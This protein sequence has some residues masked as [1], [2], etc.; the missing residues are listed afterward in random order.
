MASAEM[1]KEKL[2]MQS[3]DTP[4]DYVKEPLIPDHHKGY[5]SGKCGLREIKLGACQDP[6]NP[7]MRP[8]VFNP[9]SSLVGLVSLIIF[10]MYCISEGSAAK[11]ELGAWQS[12]VT[13]TFTWLY[14]GS[15]DAWVVFL[16]AVYF[17]FGNIRLGQDTDKPEFT[18]LS[19]FAMIFSCGVAVGLFVYGTAEPL[20]HYG[21][22]YKHSLNGNGYESDVEAA[23]MA[24]LT[25]VFH[26]GFHGWV[27]YSLVAIQLGI[28]SFRYNLP[29][30]IR[31]CFYPLLGRHTWGWIGDFIDGFSIVTIIAG[32]CTSLGLGAIQIRR[33]LAGMRVYDMVAC[34]ADCKD[35]KLMGII[36]GITALATISVVSGLHVGIKLLS[37]TALYLSFFILAVTLFYGDTWFFLNV[38]T[39]Q[40]GLYLHYAFTI[41]GFRTD[42]FAQLTDGQGNAP[43]GAGPS[44]GFMN[45]WTIFYWG[46]WIAWSPFVGSFVARISRGRTIRE[47]L[48][49]TLTVPL[50][51]SMVWFSVFG[52]AA[53]QMEWKA[54]RLHDAG[55]QLYGDPTYFQVGQG[56]QYLNGDVSGMGIQFD[57]LYA[58]GPV[59]WDISDFGT[60]DECS[61][62]NSTCFEWNVDDQTCTK[63]TVLC[64]SDTLTGWAAQQANVGCNTPAGASAS[65]DHS[66][67]CGACFAQQQHFG[68]DTHDACAV[69]ADFEKSGEPVRD[70]SDCPSWIENWNG[71][72]RFQNQCLFTDW[73]QES[74]WY[75]VMGQFGDISEFMQG[76]SIVTL[77]LYFVTSS[78]SGSLI[79]DTLSTN[80]RDEQNPLQRVV[81]AIIEGLVATG[82]VAGADDDTTAKDLLKALQAASICAGLPFTILLCFMMPAMWYGLEQDGKDKNLRPK[83][84]A[85]PVFGGVFD[86]IE[87]ALSLGKAPMPTMQVIMDTVVSI[88]LPFLSMFRILNM[89]DAN[90]EAA[91]LMGSVKANTLW[92]TFTTA[93]SMGLFIIFQFMQLDDGK[94][95]YWA[96][97]WVFYVVFCST[98]ASVRYRL[99]NFRDIQGNYIEDFFSTLFMYPCVLMQ[100]LDEAAKAPDLAVFGAAGKVVEDDGL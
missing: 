32:I 64:S 90:N 13:V 96:L 34:D 58:R 91:D 40:T 81:W 95:G 22:W 84:F 18:S 56:S 99:R 7:L 36:W 87:V 38:I 4:G 39:E 30:C 98:I 45:G 15:Q 82:L 71:D 11:D 78:D 16:I 74:S 52:G 73:D 80:G 57:G 67:G 48:N 5:G 17:K 92:M 10:S 12:W 63:E 53:I 86:V 9:V 72:T 55:M 29:M 100:M 89:M 65:N 85:V 3:Y 23:N 6:K 14:I 19:Y 68:N 70:I 51:F 97:G 42:A 24:I 43:D 35:E 25:T 28:M 61:P 20:Y 93:V 50:M 37:S 69:W 47:V 41:L 46:W 60:S 66:G 79:V 83:S 59:A 31:S 44:S 88:P 75:N 94:Q 26:W 8:F 49:F 62:Y 1:L 33:G 76:V 2:G 27:V 77:V 54:H 21:Y